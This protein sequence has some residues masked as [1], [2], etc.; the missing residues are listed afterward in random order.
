[1]GTILK[2]AALSASL[3]LTLGTLPAWAEGASDHW[4]VSALV[5]QTAATCDGGRGSIR[6][7]GNTL[8]YYD[9]GMLYSDWDVELDPD[10]SAEKSVG[11]TIHSN[12]QIRVKVAPGNGPREVTAIYERSLCGLKF[13]P[14]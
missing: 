5:H 4:K 2:F 13:V 11:A 9:E 1:M 12:R 7:V 10:G 3:A 8:S 6:V 14:D